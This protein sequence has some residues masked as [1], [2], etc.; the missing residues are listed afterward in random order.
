MSNSL[1]LAVDTSSPHS[2]YAITR[3][4]ETLASLSSDAY[5]PHSRTLF[6][7][8]QTLLRLANLEIKDLDAFAVATG[9]GS[10]TGLRVGLAAV[11][12]LAE[13][14]GKPALGINTIDALALAA[15]ISG[16]ILVLIDAG[17]GE[18]YCGLRE[19]NIDGMISMIEED[20]VGA[21]SSVLDRQTKNLN[22]SL[23]IVGNGVLKFKDRLE[24][25]AKNTG[26]DLRI[27]NYIS[28][29]FKSWQLKVD[30]Q[31]TAIVIA[32]HAH[33]LLIRGMSPEIH[34]YYIRPS[35]AEI[36]LYE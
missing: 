33:R 16:R 29:N 28:P 32:R 21:I 24:E 18:A 23:V 11:K 35:D 7:N 1:I 12:G 31:E 6:P 13:T 36:K 30:K 27:V 9:P 2:S 8:M 17:R 5:I 10:F 26:T 15:W 3:D 14:L 25:L 34:A 20:C 19:I 22:G 4:G